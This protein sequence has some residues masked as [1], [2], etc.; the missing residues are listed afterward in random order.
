MSSENVYNSRRAVYVVPFNG[1]SIKYGFTTN[2]KDAVGT[3]CGHVPVPS[4][5]P[6]GLVF[7][8]NAP[9]PG[10][11][12]KR[13]A[14]GVD[15]SYF[16]IDKLATLR[17][18]GYTITLPQVKRGGDSL[19]A[20]CRYVTIN[21]IKYAWKI[22]TRTWTRIQGDATAMGLEAPTQ[23]DRDLVWGA[24]YPKP[25]RV[26]KVVIG[27]NDSFNTYSTFC[28]PSKIDNL[29][30]GWEVMGRERTTG[31]AT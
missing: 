4:D 31:T 25:Q 14:T 6:A 7:G 9:K 16:D 29:P 12:S 10:R 18:A 11:A 19:N 27:D 3:A 20:V 24:R 22:P 23:N 15:S 30:S 13:G 28:D 2:V 17:Q 26:Q 21:G 1:T 5:Y 8:A